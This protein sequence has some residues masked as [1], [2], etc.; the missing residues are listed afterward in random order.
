MQGNLDRLAADQR[1]ALAE[2]G[3]PRDAALVALVRQRLRRR[4]PW[5]LRVLGL[6]VAA[7]LVLAAAG[8]LLFGGGGVGPASSYERLNAQAITCEPGYSA[9]G[10]Q[11]ATAASR[12]RVRVSTPTADGA[13]AEV[14]VSPLLD[15]NRWQ[16]QQRAL[17]GDWIR[18]EVSIPGI[19]EDRVLYRAEFLRSG[20]PR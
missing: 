18:V 14:E 17:F 9:I 1:A 20:Q 2:P 12:Y 16:P 6:A 10:W 11:A 4:Q 3:L 15:G 8:Q 5:H 19:E 13:V 7:V